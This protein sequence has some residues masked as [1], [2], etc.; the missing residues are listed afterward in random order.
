MLLDRGLSFVRHRQIRFWAFWLIVLALGVRLTSEIPLF[1]FQRS[2]KVN[3]NTIPGIVIV[4]AIF[5]TAA[6]SYKYLLVPVLQME[7]EIFDDKPISKFV[8]NVLF[9]TSL[10]V[11]VFIFFV[12]CYALTGPAST[13]GAAA[14]KQA[15]FD[16]NSVAG[17]FLD[18][19]HLIIFVLLYTAM[20]IIVAV[21][22]INQ[23]VKRRF[24]DIV[25][26][27]DLPILFSMVFIGIILRPMI[28]L[29]FYYFEAGVVSF[30]LIFGSLSVIGFDVLED[31]ID[32]ALAK[33]PA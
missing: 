6:W 24:S 2:I 25:V 19:Y 32:E 26:F 28:G 9:G 30:Q 20:D 15:F 14:V 29:Q 17:P 18:D 31:R 16:V 12:Y 11:S 8:F 5:T 21:G 7:K 4:F 1:F 22:S 10:A 3:E 27:V 13:S 33:P 23:G